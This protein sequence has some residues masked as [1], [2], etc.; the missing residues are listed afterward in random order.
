MLQGDPIHPTPTNI[1][2]HPPSPLPP[3]CQRIVM[4]ELIQ[5]NC[6][7]NWIRRRWKFIRHT[8]WEGYDNDCRTAMTWAA[9][10]RWKWDSP[11]T[12][13]TRKQRRREKE[14]DGVAGARCPLQ[15]LTELVGNRVSRSCEPRF[16][17]WSEVVR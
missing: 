7:K 8:A 13:W 17:T 16:T 14:L 6:E 12:T 5:L 3:F 11:R 4:L 1:P 10:G 15:Q 2:P 9:A